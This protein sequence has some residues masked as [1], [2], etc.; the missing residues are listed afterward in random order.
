MKVI[1]LILL[2]LLSYALSA[3]ITKGFHEFRMY[4][5][6]RISIDVLTMK[7][8]RETILI[9]YALPN[10]N[11]TEQ[12]IGK[13]MEEGDDWH[14]DIQHIKAQ[15][16]FLRKSL[17]NKNIVVIYLENSYKSWPAWKSKNKDYV[18]KTKHIVDSI[19]NLF[20]GNKSIYLNGHSGGGRFIFNYL[21]GIEEIPHYVKNISF[22]DSNYGYDT[23][24]LEKFVEWIQENKTARLNVFAYNDSVALLDGKRIVSDTGGTW[25]RSRL[26]LKHLSYHFR[27]QKIREDSLIVY[28]TLNK[29]IKL[30]LKSNPD[31]KIYHTQQVELNGFIHSVLAGTAKDEK[32]YKYF[33]KRAY[34]QLIE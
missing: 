14:Y 25:Y 18:V 26:M 1:Q 33:D 28:Q 7:K 21:D 30:F 23:S 12:T 32:G 15:T 5:D 20:K 4:Q 3:Q 9:L 16:S 19:M 34:S 27:F 8:G 22:L 24:Y 29:R 6:V 11:T 13:K 31:K 10:G 17:K 2:L